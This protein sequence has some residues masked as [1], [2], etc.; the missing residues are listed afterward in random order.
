MIQPQDGNLE[1]FP[2][3][4]GPEA[5]HASPGLF[6]VYSLNAVDSSNLSIAA[7]DDVNI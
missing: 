7:K 3:G 5:D 6:Q 1:E 4:T 2:P